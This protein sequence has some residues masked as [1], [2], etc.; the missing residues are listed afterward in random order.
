MERWHSSVTMM[1]KLSMGMLGLYSMGSGCLNRPLEF[2]HRF[3]FEVFGQLFALEHG[4][5]AL[6]GADADPRGG[7][8]G[9]A[10]QALDDVLLGELEVVV[11]RGVLLEFLQG[12]V[13]EVAAVDQKQYAF[14]A[15]EFDEPVDERDGGEGFAGA[16][17]HLDEGAGAVFLERLFEVVDGRDLRGPEAGFLERGHVLHTLKERAATS[18]VVRRCFGGFKVFTPTLALP[19]QGEGIVCF[20]SRKGRGSNACVFEPGD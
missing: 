16:R 6:D 12:L 18:A 2:I 3:F 8:E 4:V 19:H 5:H 15:R 14:C 13:A 7:V 11:G 17:G 10:L 20:F 1:S 9:V